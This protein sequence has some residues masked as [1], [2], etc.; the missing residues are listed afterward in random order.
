MKD[1]ALLRQCMPHLAM[2]LLLKERLAGH[3]MR[4]SNIEAALDRLEDG[5]LFLD[6]S[7]RPVFANRAGAALLAAE[8]ALHSALASLT[9]ARRKLFQAGGAFDIPRLAHAALRLRVVLV[10][11]VCEVPW[12]PDQTRAVAFITDPEA[13]DRQ[14]NEALARIYGLTPAETR[15]VVEISRGDGRAAT[16]RPLAISPATARAHLSRI[17]DKTGLHRQ[18]EHVRVFLDPGLS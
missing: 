2:A 6:A 7:A 5:I 17:F 8:P 11:E 16:A 9:N 10:G 15:F 12:L 13:S 14:C 4:A 3:E 18:A 1:V